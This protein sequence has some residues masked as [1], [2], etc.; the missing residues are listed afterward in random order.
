MLTLDDAKEYQDRLTELRRLF[1]RFPD[2][3]GHEEKTVERI[4]AILT[5]AGIDHEVV[6]DGG[7]LA[8]IYGKG[9]EPEAGKE[10]WKDGYVEE[11]TPCLLT[12]GCTA[13]DRTLSWKM[14]TV[15]LRADVDALPVPENPCNLNQEKDCFSEVE[16]V[17]HACGHDSHIAMMIVAAEYLAAH[18]EEISGRIIVMFERGEEGPNNIV[19][20][21]RRMIEK[22]L[23]VDTIYAA[24]VYYALESGKIAV[25]AGPVM[26]GGV[27][28]KILIRGRGGHGSRPDLAANPI[29][30]YVMIQNA[31]ND[32]RMKHVGP[33]HTLVFAPTI[34]HSGD[35]DNVIPGELTFGGNVRLYDLDDGV[36]FTEYFMETLDHVCPLYGCEY[37]VIYCVG[38]KMP[39]KNDAECAKIAKKAA[40]S[41]VGE[42]NVVEFEPWMACESFCVPLAIWPGVYTFIGNRNPEKGTGALHHSP[43]FDVDEE[44]MPAGF[45]TAVNYALS[46]LQDPEIKPGHGWFDGSAAD[47]YEASRYSAE[48]VSYLRYGTPYTIPEG[49]R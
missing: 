26:A 21:F 15:L 38:P 8:Y 11:G 1:H 16:G 39:V 4:S 34:V 7:I 22:N 41:T 19:H 44:I 49:K 33:F 2:R 18:R 25:Q 12:H 9:Y 17:S 35:V 5:K 40:V 13:K 37:E 6:K 20:I 23:H 45:S 31:L 3:T 24:H 14:R 46:F 36:R 27:F 28:Y 10:P 47:V 42:E 32:F 48:V 29:D 30:C 43:K